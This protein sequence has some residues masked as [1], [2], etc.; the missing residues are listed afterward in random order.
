MTSSPETKRANKTNHPTTRSRPVSMILR[1]YNINP[2]IHI[3]E[4][5]GIFSPRQCL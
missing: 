1:N 5:S 4:V 3:G 2:A